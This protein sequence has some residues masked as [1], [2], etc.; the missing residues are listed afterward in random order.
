MGGGDVLLALRPPR[1]TTEAASG[2][3]GRSRGLE[4]NRLLG[5]ILIGREREE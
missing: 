5:A 2:I 1:G 4:P 3:V